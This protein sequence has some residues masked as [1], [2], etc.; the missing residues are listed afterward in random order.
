[1]TGESLEGSWLIQLSE[2]RTILLQKSSAAMGILMTVTGGVSVLSCLNVKLDGH[3][4]VL[5][6]LMIRIE[7]L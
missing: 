5:K 6:R 3:L 2:P 4:S 1:M 7:R